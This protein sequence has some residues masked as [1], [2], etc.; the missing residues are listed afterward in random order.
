LSAQRIECDPQCLIL[1]AEDFF[2][3][4]RKVQIRPKGRPR[5]FQG[6]FDRI[7]DNI[8][9]LDNREKNDNYS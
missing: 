1:D 8:R 9:V 7:F 4:S 3:V 2:D 5:N 6:T